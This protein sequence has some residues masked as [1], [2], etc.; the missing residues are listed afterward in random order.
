ME[1]MET[2][3]KEELGLKLFLLKFWNT[4]HKRKNQYFFFLP[5]IDAPKK[6]ILLV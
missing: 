3:K 1:K 2:H 6:M 4:F 5:I